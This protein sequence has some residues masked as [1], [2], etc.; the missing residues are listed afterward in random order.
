MT[1]SFQAHEV[2]DLHRLWVA[3]SIHI[4]PCEIYQHDMF[5]AVL[6]RV[7]QFLAQPLILCQR[8][9]DLEVS[10]KLYGSSP[11]GVFPLLTVPAM[12]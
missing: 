3:Y 1:E 2:V 4:V 8:C 11:S 6:L 5:C 10:I 7:Q 12:A 9:E